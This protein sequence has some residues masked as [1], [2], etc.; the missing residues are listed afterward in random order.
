MNKLPVALLVA[1]L[2]P[3]EVEALECF[4]TGGNTYLESVTKCDSQSL[5][6]KVERTDC[7][8]LSNPNPVCMKAVINKGDSKSTEQVCMCS[9]ADVAEK[10]INNDLKLLHVLK[11]EVRL[12]FW[13]LHDVRWK[14]KF[15]AGNMCKYATNIEYCSI[16]PT[17]F[18]NAAI[19]MLL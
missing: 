15:R 2:I 12:I 7:T 5:T 4:C 8:M 19:E 1:F 3:S 14:V 6:C 13:A 9:P 11:P 16:Y 17:C 10:V 18:R